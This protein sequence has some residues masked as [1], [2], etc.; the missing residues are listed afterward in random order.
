MVVDC[1]NTVELVMRI[2]KHYAT[3]NRELRR[4]RVVFIDTVAVRE[5]IRR[6]NCNHK[7]GLTARISHALA[8]VAVRYGG[9]FT[10]D[11][12]YMWIELP[13]KAIAGANKA[14]LLRVV[15]EC[16]KKKTWLELKKA[17]NMH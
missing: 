6:L 7:R 15:Y 12:N 14:E 2:I 11:G 10:V 8:C 13:I 16:T 1:G 4:Y 3:H 5:F 17:K 9:Y